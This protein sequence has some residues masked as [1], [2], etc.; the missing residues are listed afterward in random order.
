MLLVSHC[1]PKIFVTL[2]L[3]LFHFNHK[4]LLNKYSVKS[5]TN[6]LKKKIVIEAELGTPAFE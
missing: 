4:L 3:H 2:K 6:T 1:S 5:Y